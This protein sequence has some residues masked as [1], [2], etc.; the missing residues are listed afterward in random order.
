MVVRPG[1]DITADGGALIEIID[2]GLGMSAERLDEEN[3]RLIRR[4]R[5][6][7]VPTKVLG[8]FV[9]GSLARRS[10]IRVA[11]SRTPGGGVTGTV[12]LPAALL[13]A[14]QPMRHPVH[15]SGGDRGPGSIGAPATPEPGPG[16]ESTTPEPEPTPATPLP[17]RTPAT[18]P[19]RR[20]TAP[21]QP[22]EL[23]RRLPQR[24]DEEGA[25]AASEPR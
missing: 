22:G 20:S 10:G 2:H 15:G 25:D 13:L 19:E 24:T 17:V 4:E 6:D 8:L 14:V 3:S 5:L 21:S 1:T 23:P 12:W 9:V 18:L 11:L 16:P 7:L